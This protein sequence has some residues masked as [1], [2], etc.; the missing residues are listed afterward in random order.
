MK[1]SGTIT[2]SSYS[3]VGGIV[4]YA[5]GTSD[6]RIAISNCTN[7][8]AINGTGSQRGGVA[9]YITYTDL[10]DCKNTAAINGASYIGGVVGQFYYSTADNCTN[11]G[12]VTGTST[13][14]GGICGYSYG[15]ST[16]HCTYTKCSNTGTISSSSYNIGGVIGY[17]G[18]Y[19]D[20]DQCSNTGQVKGTGTGSYNV[21]GVVG[22]LYSSS[23][24]RNSYNRGAVSTSY[25]STS[26]SYGIGGV[27]GYVY[28]SSSSYNYVDNCYNTGTVTAS[29]TTSFCAGG[30]VG[31]NYYGYIRNCYNGNT[32][33]LNSSNTTYSGN[34]CG[35]NYSGYVQYCHY[36]SGML[37]Y[38]TTTRVCGSGTAATNSYSV[39]H[40]LT[41]NATCTLSTSI[42]GS[43]E[44][45]MGLKYWCQ[46]PSLSGTPSLYK[47]W[48]PDASPWPNLGMP[49]F[50]TCPSFDPPAATSSSVLGCSS[51]SLSVSSP[52]SG[53]TVNWYNAP[54]DGT[55]LIEG[56]T[57]YTVTESGSYYAESKNTSTGCVSSSRTRI[58]A[59]VYPS[60]LPY[61]GLATSYADGALVSVTLGGGFSNYSWTSNYG[62]SGSTASVTGAAHTGL[63]FHATASNSGNA[64]TASVDIPVTVNETSGGSGSAS[65]GTKIIY[66]SSLVRSLKGFV[67]LIP[68]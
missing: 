54:E 28:G 63:Q 22:Y 48:Q 36:R 46:T 64:C 43:T 51:A 15:S 45:V 24:L 2:G 19:N 34:I 18:Y 53:Y 6:S 33:T 60:T 68:K 16:G 7:G 25:S 66:C 49:V 4:G 37:S 38:G 41:S 58:N 17:A 31:R 67:L 10:I 44:R 57:S 65:C 26:T 12:N 62:G 47:D 14:V 39:T 50:Y 42:N 52:G 30:V 23:T 35:Y 3:Y 56:Q 32:I 1:T 61:T 13:N 8:A 27:V 55:L 29:S 11:S 5:N 40:S 59:T 20:I 9:G 21:G